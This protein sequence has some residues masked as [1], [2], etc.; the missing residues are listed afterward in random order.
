MHTDCAMRL[1]NKVAALTSLFTH[2]IFSMK[3]RSN[4]E[5]LDPLS[6]GVQPFLHDI[7]SA[8]MSGLETTERDNIMKVRLFTYKYTYKIYIQIHKHIH[9]KHIHLNSYYKKNTVMSSIHPEPF[10]NNT[11][12]SKHAI[13]GFTNIIGQPDRSTSS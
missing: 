10:I 8:A 13:I 11:N 4:T 7:C 12:A 2:S 6:A 3:S 9:L 5:V 1:R